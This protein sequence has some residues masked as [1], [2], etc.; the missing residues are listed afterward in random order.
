[1]KLQ[2]GNLSAVERTV[3]TA[4]AV[5]L[6]ALALRGRS[7]LIRA[8]AGTASAAL[9]ARAVAGHCA[10][11]GALRGDCSIFE[12][13]ADQWSGM[14]GTGRAERHGFPGSPAHKA[15]S[16]AVDESVSE[17]FPAS[18]PPASRLPDDPPVNADAKWAAARAAK[19]A[20]HGNSP[21]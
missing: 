4:F 12:G 20:R 14:S 13:I 1:M 5:V 21:I 10:V 3:S 2:T 6:S 8:V 16:E 19:A 11:K 18:D 17:S 7:P 15:R 9:L